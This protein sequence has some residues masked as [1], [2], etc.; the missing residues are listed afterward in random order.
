MDNVRAAAETLG[1]A[2]TNPAVR[3]A[4]FAYVAAQS[5]RDARQDTTIADLK[6]SLASL[7]RDLDAA[8]DGA[9]KRALESTELR[10]HGLGALI[11]AMNA[12]DARLDAIETRGDIRTAMLQTVIGQLDRLA[13]PPPRPVPIDDDIDDPTGTDAGA[14]PYG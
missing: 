10:V 7:R 11:D 13:P 1:Q 9:V 12:F 14:H 4:W 3:A 8:I 6:G 5:E 2:I